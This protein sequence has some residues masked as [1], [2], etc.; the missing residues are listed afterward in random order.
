M[1]LDLVK[2]LEDDELK[3]RGLTDTLVFIIANSLMRHIG[4]NG[5]W[6]EK[7]LE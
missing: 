5:N 7:L 2:A 3:M 1:T 6:I 4:S